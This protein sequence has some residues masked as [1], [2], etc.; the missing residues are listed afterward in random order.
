MGVELKLYKGD[1]MKIVEVI[2]VVICLTLLIGKKNVLAEGQQYHY[3]SGT[4]Q[5]PWDQ[6]Q[7][8]GRTV[9][10]KEAAAG[11]WLTEDYS[12][13]RRRRHV[14]NDVQP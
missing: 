4:N 5:Q 9:H 12:H 13:P 2:K 7:L 1:S 8:R 14:H 11:W 10:R 6:H 3:H